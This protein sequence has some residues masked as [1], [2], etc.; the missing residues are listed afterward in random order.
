MAELFKQV[1]EEPE[2]KG[3]FREIRFAISTPQHSWC[4][5]SSEWLL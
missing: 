1:L 2:F 4:Q 5:A 3:I